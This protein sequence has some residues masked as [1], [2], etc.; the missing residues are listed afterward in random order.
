MFGFGSQ[1]K[2]DTPRLEAVFV[3]ETGR[4]REENQDNVLVSLGRGV[5]CVA[6]GIGG[7]RDG[8]R[9]SATVCHELRMMIHAA[10][11]DFATR[12]AAICK[13]L[14]DANAA[15]YVRA[16]GDAGRRVGTTAAVLAFDLRDATRAAVISV[17]DSRIYRV[18]HGL[19]GLLTRDHRLSNSNVLTRAIGATPTLRSD[20]QEIRIERG[21][22]FVLCTDGVSGVVS[23]ARI[24][25][26][27][28]G[29][30]LESSAARLAGEVEKN[31]APDN[32][33]F[34]LVGT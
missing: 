28:S 4:V 26:F 11:D 2:K 29:P 15:L 5:F 10:G 19:C 14:E 24:A 32:Y 9:A 20:A 18:R 12:I 34:I 16:E 8:A 22:R 23:D 25:L 13:G 33:S 7:C 31:G 17:G 1:Q 27:A 30:T 21:D 6:D 3:C